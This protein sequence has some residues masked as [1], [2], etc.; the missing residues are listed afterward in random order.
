MGNCCTMTMRKATVAL[1]SVENIN[2][3]LRNDDMEEKLSEI[4]LV[5]FLWQKRKQRSNSFLLKQNC[6]IPEN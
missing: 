1:W 6:S 2:Q 4:T 3:H 5:K